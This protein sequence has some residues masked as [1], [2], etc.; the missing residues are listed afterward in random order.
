MLSLSFTAG[1]KLSCIQPQ[2]IP[3]NSD[4]VI[5]LHFK[6]GQ[7][8]IQVYKKSNIPVYVII[9]LFIFH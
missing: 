1:W 6:K 7:V 9:I 5:K 4:T 3:Y 2:D 8:Q